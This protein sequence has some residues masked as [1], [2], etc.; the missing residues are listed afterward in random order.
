M[1]LKIP[2]MGPTAHPMS[3]GFVMPMSMDNASAQINAPLVGVARTANSNFQP[4]VDLP[5]TL[6]NMVRGY[7]P[8]PIKSR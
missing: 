6:M 8:R 1:A 4:V 2:T 7:N 3:S 5:A